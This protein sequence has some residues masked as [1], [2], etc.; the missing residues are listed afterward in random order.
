MA[1]AILGVI[2]YLLLYVVVLVLAVAMNERKGSA[3]LLVTGAFALPL[4]ILGVLVGYEQ[5]ALW[6]KERDFAAACKDAEAQG[7]RISRSYSEV[8]GFEI[9][10]KADGNAYEFGALRHPVQ[11]L[12][13][14]Y[15]F[16]QFGQHRFVE[17]SPL[18]SI[19]TPA[20]DAVLFRIRATRTAA[21]KSGLSG[22]SSVLDMSVVDNRTGEIFASKRWVANA[23]GRLC[24]AHARGAGM[25]DFVTRVLKPPTRG[26]KAAAPP[27]YE[28]PLDVSVLKEFPERLP[29]GKVKSVLNRALNC[30]GAIELPDPMQ[31]MRKSPELPSGEW[32]SV[33]ITG[34]GA[35]RALHWRRGRPSQAYCAGG[36][37][38]VFAT[39]PDHIPLLYVLQ[40][41]LPMRVTGIYRLRLKGADAAPLH[42]STPQVLDFSAERDA[43]RFTRVH[44]HAPLNLDEPL[45]RV[46]QAY[47][48][49]LPLPVAETFRKP[50]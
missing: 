24:P 3:A 46:R 47:K 35:V 9:E 23:S 26:P 49:T 38:Y 4:A 14:G 48:V 11:A 25:E 8:P 6:L 15:E 10:T 21:P 39:E 37:L 36:A 29:A 50:R 5:G 18:H 16:V 22:V 40:L 1:I 43:L 30:A 33:R 27:L 34:E 41:E 12:S 44:F 20:P 28:V 31:E 17:A 45:A 32:P 7:E 2:A 13:L 19:S 42:A